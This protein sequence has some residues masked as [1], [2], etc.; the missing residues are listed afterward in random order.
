MAQI[1]G[2]KLHSHTPAISSR[3]LK[4]SAVG[5]NLHHLLISASTIMDTINR[6]NNWLESVKHATNAVQSTL[7]MY[8]GLLLQSKQ[9]HATSPTAQLTKAIPIFEQ[10]IVLFK[11]RLAELAWFKDFLLGLRIALIERACENIYGYRS[12]ASRS[13]CEQL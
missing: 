8:R 2:H 10:I 4:T 1:E 6:I 13:V 11:A 12:S 3:L 5:L 7:N 9:T